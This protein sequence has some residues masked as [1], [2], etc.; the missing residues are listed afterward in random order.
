[1]RGL[2][3]EKG[4]VKQLKLSKNFR[5]GYRE[6]ERDREAETDIQKQRERDKERQRDRDRRS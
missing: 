6:R 1:M 3:I 5:E 2:R 4:C